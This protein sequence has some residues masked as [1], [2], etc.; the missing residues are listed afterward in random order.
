VINPDGSATLTPVPYLGPDGRVLDKIRVS[1]T[2]D[3][4]LYRGP[5]ASLTLIPPPAGTAPMKGGKIR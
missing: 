1:D 3:A 5:H 4:L 2:V